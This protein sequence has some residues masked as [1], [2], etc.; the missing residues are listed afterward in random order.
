MDRSNAF[1]WNGMD[2]SFLDEIELSGGAFYEDGLQRDLLYMM[3]NNG[4]NTIRLRIWNDPPGG[5]CNLER[6]L[7]MAKRI[8]ALGLHFLLDFHYSD[9]WADPAHQTKPK[10]WESLSFNGLIHVVYD[11]TR[12]VLTELQAQGTLPDM[13]QIGNEITPGMLWDDG[14]VGGEEYNSEEQW[15][16]FAALVKSGIEAA[17]AVDADINVMIHIDRGGDNE[18]CRMFYDRFARLGVEFDTIGLSF[19]PWWHGTLDDLRSNLHDL[20]LRYDKDIVVVETA[21]PWTIEPAEGRSFIVTSEEQLHEGYPA[22]VQGQTDYMR[23]FIRI[24]QETP[25]GRGVGFHYWEPC[26]IPSKDEWSVGH[27]NNW[28]NLTLFDFEG[29]K[30]KTLEVLKEVVRL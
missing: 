27:A 5:F 7:A 17:K 30:L 20:A 18:T 13:V 29:R 8:K 11:Y 6:T 2:I 10:A 26:W 4:V 22:T 3:A 19:Y 25:N 14:R 9:V 24:V 15:A 28:S 12:M 16:Q 21:Y 23:D 1:F